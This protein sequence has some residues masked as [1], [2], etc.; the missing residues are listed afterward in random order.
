MVVRVAKLHE[1]ILPSKHEP[2]REIT[3]PPPAPAPGKPLAPSR[4]LRNQGTITRVLSSVSN[5]LSPISPAKK[6]QL[7]QS[8]IP[9]LHRSSPAQSP[10]KR[11]ATRAERQGC[12]SRGLPARSSPMSAGS[13][14]SSSHAAGN[15]RQYAM[16]SRRAQQV[17]SMIGSHGP[18]GC[19]AP[20]SP[21]RA[22]QPRNSSVYRT[23]TT[24]AVDALA[25]RRS[26]YP[27]IRRGSQNLAPAYGMGMA[28]ALPSYH[29]TAGAL[30]Q[31]R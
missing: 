11:M 20:Q 1:L 4:Q 12:M 26:V 10:A 31:V 7:Q 28:R 3:A 29:R 5:T 18:A 17:V 16:L 8:R 25:S 9:V 22:L 21:L 6:N 23:M 30:V 19:S 13:S 2:V 14:A 15:A 27:T 24:S